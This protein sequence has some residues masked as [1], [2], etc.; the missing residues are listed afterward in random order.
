MRKTTGDK[1]VNGTGCCRWHWCQTDKEGLDGGFASYLWCDMKQ[2][3]R[4]F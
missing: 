1:G 4:S 3:T 2:G